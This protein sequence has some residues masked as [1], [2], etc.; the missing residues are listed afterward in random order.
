MRSKLSKSPLA[1]AKH[2]L[3]IGS[4]VLPLYAHKYSPKLYTQPQLFACLVLKVFFKTDYRGLSA[5]LV[6]FDALRWRLGFT[7]S[8]PHF[9]TFQKASR[10]LLKTARARKL[11]ILTIKRFLKR[12]R[13]VK[14]VALDST[15]FE[16]GQR[17][18][19]YVRRRASVT[20]QWQT[21][22]YS[23]FAKLE[24]AF[25]CQSHLMVGVL[26]G[27]GPKVDV[28]RFVPLLG[29]AAKVVRIDSAL[30]DAGYDSEPN[31]RFAREKLGIRSYMP[32][33][34]GR[35]SKK[36]P[37]GKYRRQM[38]Q[39][40]NKRYGSYGQRWQSESGFSMIKRRLAT[41][42]QGRSYHSQCRD[43]YLLAIS[44]NILL[45]Y[46]AVGFLQSRSGVFPW[47]PSSII[48][49][50]Y[51][52]NY[53]WLLPGLSTMSSTRRWSERNSSRGGRG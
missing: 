44:Y 34:H 11:F 6:D 39:R 21:V 14:R 51:R 1:V 36:L 40:L 38:K 25:D 35:P 37:T 43:L 12:R 5:L 46:A 15:G 32:A 33:T 13:R 42:V 52:D 8:V 45:L 29:G 28:N 48:P 53:T 30:A 7:E 10:R 41:A 19:Y 2:A 23:R 18:S 26:V 3:A 9:T 50:S 4:Q 31:H 17:S 24:A 20:K 27:R 16:L 47:P 22:L 49:P